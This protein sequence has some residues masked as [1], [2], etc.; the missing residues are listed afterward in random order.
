M[1]SKSN[2]ARAL[3]SKLNGFT[4][5]PLNTKAPKISADACMVQLLAYLKEIKGK[6]CNPHRFSLFQ[7]PHRSA[8]SSN[9]SGNPNPWMSAFGEMAQYRKAGSKRTLFTSVARRAK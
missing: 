9:Y 5:L 4:K 2:P 6:H 8:S 3:L 1:A 7:R